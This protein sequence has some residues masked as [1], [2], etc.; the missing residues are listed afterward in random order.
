MTT[1][2]TTSSSSSTKM[3]GLGGILSAASE[4]DMLNA[5][6]ALGKIDPIHESGLDM[7]MAQFNTRLEALSNPKAY[8]AK[9]Q[10]AFDVSAKAMMTLTK[11]F[12][13]QAWGWTWQSNLPYRRLTTRN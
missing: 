6:P 13:A 1:T 11:A 3:S 7:E 10:T 9:R 5:S 4:A 2:T 12:S 8:V